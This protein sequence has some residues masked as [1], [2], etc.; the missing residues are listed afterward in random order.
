[1]DIANT[2]NYTG[3]RVGVLYDYYARRKLFMYR[4]WFTNMTFL[5]RHK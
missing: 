4:F 5:E 2:K 3:I 1:M